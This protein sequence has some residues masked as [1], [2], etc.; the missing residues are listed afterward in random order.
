MTAIG[1]TTFGV[2]VWAGVVGVGLVLCYEL[3][4]IA[5]EGGWFQR[6]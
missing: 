3:Y 6:G 5:R 4:A 2:I 1:A